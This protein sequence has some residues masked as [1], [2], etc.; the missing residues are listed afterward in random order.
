MML[1]GKIKMLPSGIKQKTKFR[2]VVLG[3]DFVKGRDCDTHTF[4]PN[5]TVNTARAKVYDAVV[6]GYCLKSCDV[7]Q[8]YTFGQADRRTFVHCPPGRS[9]N[10]DE[11][12]KPL[13]YELTGNCY[14]SPGAPKR[15][16]IAVHNELIKLGFIQSTVDP[17]LY[18]KGDCST[19]VYTD[20]FLTSFPDTACGL[21]QYTELVNML[22]T[23]FELGDDGFQDC[24]DFI[25]MHFEFNADRT[26][27]HITQPLKVDELIEGAGLQECRPAF[28][29][30][31]PNT[32]VSTRECPAIDDLKQIALMKTK[33]YK[34][35][36]GQ[37]L[38]LARGSRPDI[39]YQVNAL[40]TVAHNPGIA[41]WNAST[42][43]IR[44]ISH[45][46]TM[47]VVYRRPTI[48]PTGP[49]IWS[50]ATWAPNYGSYYDNYRSTSGNCISGNADGSN[51]LSWGAT[52][53]PI[54]AL[55]SAESETYSASEVAKDAAYVK[56][57][58]TELKLPAQLP[59]ILNCDNQSTIKQT[60][61]FV[62]Q[63]NSRHIGMRAHYLRFQCHSNKLKLAFV[64]TNDQIA[65]LLTKLVPQP[66]HE[67]LRLI[68]GVMPR[69]QFLGLPTCTSN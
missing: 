49:T 58:F 37:C 54:I 35:R 32:L 56:K 7:K 40:S 39:A 10:Y 47:G 67:R 59:F 48:A 46:R 11:N 22:T 68:M 28:T 45:T 16:H 50:D 8:A 64:P 6:K 13:V 52:R 33:C 63:K 24:T 12:G 19:L 42:H 65:D 2:S 17:S 9:R 18:C 60:L 57:V 36:I 14:G 44:Y 3:N 5:A 26:A 31:V 1:L 66:L 29:P 53:Q 27:V 41:H 51:L 21:R 23:K 61:N 34:K 55:S 15:W 43:L 62:D 38:W 4:A 25:G 30:G 20:D 69:H